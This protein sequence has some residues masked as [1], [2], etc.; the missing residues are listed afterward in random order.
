M[1]TLLQMILEQRKSTKFRWTIGI[2]MGSLIFIL[3]KINHIFVRDGIIAFPSVFGLAPF[4]FYNALVFSLFFILLITDVF[5]VTKHLLVF[6]QSWFLFT[7]ERLF[8]KDIVKQGSEHLEELL[9]RL[10]SL[11]QVIVF[12]MTT[13]GTFFL[14]FY[15]VGDISNY[16]LTMSLITGFYILNTLYTFKFRRI[17]PK[18]DLFDRFAPLVPFII[19]LFAY[20]FIITFKPSYVSYIMD[21][22]SVYLVVEILS[23]SYSNYD[24]YKIFYKKEIKDED[25]IN[26]G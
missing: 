11:N 24:Y 20:I 13:I 2:I 10:L 4:D 12:I 3:M 7:M 18:V 1:Y 6:F 5:M 23:V 15:I 19:V 26:L 16:V 14:A 21:F 22:L 9:I 17:L 25:K 8:D